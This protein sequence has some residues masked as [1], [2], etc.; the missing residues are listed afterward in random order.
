[1]QNEGSKLDL[2]TENSFKN[3]IKF[4]AIMICL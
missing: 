3:I 4:N 1:M 2:Q